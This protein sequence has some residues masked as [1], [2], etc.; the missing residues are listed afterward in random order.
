MMPNGVD[1]SFFSFLSFLNRHPMHCQAIC[2]QC[3]QADLAFWSSLVQY[4]NNAGDGADG[5]H[6]AISSFYIWAW[7]ANADTEFGMGGMVESGE[8]LT[9]AAMIVHCTYWKCMKTQM[10]LVMLAWW[11]QVRESDQHD[12]ALH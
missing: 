11:S 6:N 8:T 4:L 7:D 1:F 5:K 9:N 2:L 3:V 12:C 10:S